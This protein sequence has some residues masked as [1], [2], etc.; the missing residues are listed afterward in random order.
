MDTFKL[1]THWTFESFLP[2]SITRSKYDAFRQIHRTS[3]TCFQ[4]VARLEDLVREGRMV[5]WCLVSRLT[6]DLCVSVRSLVDLLQIM[7][8][9]EFMDAHDWC[10]KLS[11]YARMTTER[12]MPE[13][14]PPY[15]L[16]LSSQKP[17]DLYAWCRKFVSKA[18]AET[19]L[20][21][22]PALYQ[23]FI[24]AND[25]RS[26]MN[27]VLS[28]LD[29]EVG[30]AVG[31][32]SGHMDAVLRRSGLP[33]RLRAELEIAAM[34]LAQ[35]GT[36]LELLVLVGSGEEAVLIG[37]RKGVRGADFFSAWLECVACKYSPSA[38]TLRHS[39]GLADE[40]HP[41]TV[42]VLA[43]DVNPGD[44]TCAI[45]EGEADSS[46][47][48]RRLEQVFPKVTRLHVFEAHGELL[49]PEQCRSLHDLACL[50]LERGLSQVFA[51]AGKPGLGLA[52]IKQLR[53]EIPVVMNTFNLGGGLFPTAAERAVISME[54]VRSIPA[55][56]FLLGLSTSVLTWS[57]ASSND[58]SSRPHHSS[59]AVLAQFF[60]HCTLRLEQNLFSVE[61]HCDDVAEKYV[62][63]RFMGGSADVGYRSVLI[64][65]ML[66][67]LEGEGFSVA[68]SGG[69]LEAIRVG[70]K[71]VLLQRNLV[72]LGLLVAWIQA[73]SPFERQDAGKAAESFRE[74]LRQS[75]SNLL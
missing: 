39:L 8:P 7:N 19:T 32:A 12:A 70:E 47:L 2:G 37:K 66:D 5:D 57:T 68:A 40:E 30:S 35:G 50:C 10:A 18:Q 15:H 58:E 1:F 71:D 22:T 31:E 17:G 51:L 75:Q 63:F 49:R 72:C 44:D 16:P 13:A 53:L 62:R 48:M 54:D 14:T 34:D 55:W 36:L 42:L 4:I 21:I 27:D 24:E 43:E 11:F 64:L 73:R 52:G 26:V 56:S 9:I 46:A 65:A 28:A 3:S 29:P 41:L 69:Y 60:M 25:T 59:Y 23:Y 61:C 38:L 74:L 20:I 33:E 6:S 67:I 45:W